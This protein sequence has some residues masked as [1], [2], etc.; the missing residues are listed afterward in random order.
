MINL[1]NKIPTSISSS[2]EKPKAMDFDAHRE[3]GIKLIQQLSP[4]L[5]TDH[6]LHD[7]GITL[8]EELCYAITDLAYRLDYPKPYQNIDCYSVQV[9]YLLNFLVPQ[10]E[11]YDDFFF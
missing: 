1:E 4:D 3:E 9:D 8:L 5:W 6:N 7:P 11:V 10:D 2:E